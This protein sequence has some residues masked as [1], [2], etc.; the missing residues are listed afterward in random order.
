MTSDG[1]LGLSCECQG[2]LLSHAR[3]RARA[4]QPFSLSALFSTSPFL[5]RRF[6]FLQPP[7]SRREPRVLRVVNA[8][9][10]AHGY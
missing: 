9:S 6:V 10:S 2:R 7:W 3:P 4:E 8:P 5:H 1:N